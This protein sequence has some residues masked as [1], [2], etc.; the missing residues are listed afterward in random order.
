MIYQKMSKRDK[1][2]IQSILNPNK[3]THADIV[4]VVGTEEKE[5]IE[6]NI[7]ISMA[8]AIKKGLDKNPNYKPGHIKVK[9]R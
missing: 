4:W 2:K 8:Y 1:R 5:T 3:P 7:P 6:I 9:P